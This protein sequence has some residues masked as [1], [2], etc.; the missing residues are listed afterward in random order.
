V[1]QLNTLIRSS[2]QSYATTSSHALLFIDISD[3]ERLNITQGRAVGEEVLR[4]VVRHAR[5]ALR[6]TDILFRNAGDG[7]VAFLGATD[8][9]TADLV[10]ARILETM[11]QH[12]LHING[13]ASVAV[14]MTVTTT[15]APRDGI[16]LN[17]LL[18]AA[19]QSERARQQDIKA[20]KFISHASES[21]TNARRIVR[22]G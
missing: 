19:K 11:A 18:A 3:L 4:H 10:A 6:I 8:G 12:P 20:Q 14:Q 17:E 9:E 13:G 7:F 5:S 22:S 16:S 1:Q 21:G 2:Q 15:C